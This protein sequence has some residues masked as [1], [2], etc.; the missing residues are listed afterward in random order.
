MILPSPEALRRSIAAAIEP[1]GCALVGGEIGN[2]G[3][4]VLLTGIAGRGA[5]M[6][7]L[8]R[9][10]SDTAPTAAVDWRVSSFDGPYCRA[11]DVLR[12][13]ATGFG[14]LG[15]GFTMALRSG[16][17][18]LIE[19]QLITIDFSMP[20]YQAWLLVDYLQHDGTVWHMHPNGKNPARQYAPGVHVNL[21]DP[22][23][24]GERWA[25]GEPYGTDM[26]IALASSEPLFTQKRK[27][28]EPADGYLAALR[29]AIETAQRRNERLAADALVL[30]TEPKH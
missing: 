5:A 19:G 24:G 17:R 6:D 3:G 21:G 22:T 26:I 14:T 9:A 7:E 2:P 8:H 13:V 23:T 10:V 4:N 25:V 20:N 16:N 1:V 30:T 15:P 11:L 29:A 18:P 12:P 27:E 28:L